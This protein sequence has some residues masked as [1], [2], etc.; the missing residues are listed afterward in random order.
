MEYSLVVECFSHG[1]SVLG[2]Q[3]EEANILKQST[4][5][6]FKWMRSSV[7]HPVQNYIVK[8]GSDKRYSLPIW[9]IPWNPPVFCCP[10][11]RRSNWKIS[12]REQDKQNNKS[13]CTSMVLSMVLHSNTQ[14]ACWDLNAECSGQRGN[15]LILPWV[16]MQL[17]MWSQTYMT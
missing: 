1:L 4:T 14:G 16:G 12:W 2:L 3:W 10:L 8:C 7:Q 6:S 5:I 11:S 17:L 9:R 15:K 13:I